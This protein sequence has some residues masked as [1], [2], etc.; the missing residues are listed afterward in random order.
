MAVTIKDL[1]REAGVSV[2]TVS[3]AL[4]GL[5]GVSIQT[6]SRILELAKT[7]GYTRNS[8]A[9][10]LKTGRKNR[11]GLVVSG[12]GE[13]LPSELELIAEFLENCFRRNCESRVE[14]FNFFHDGV[15][16]ALFQD[17]QMGGIVLCGYFGPQ[18]MKRITETRV[19]FVQ[20]NE[21]N[22]SA[23]LFPDHADCVVKL[24]NHLIRTGR[25]RIAYLDGE[26]NRFIT[27]TEGR[28]GFFDAMKANGIP[29]DPSRIYVNSF[30]RSFQEDLVLATEKFFLNRP[31]PADAVIC[32]TPGY[33]T[34]LILHLLKQGIQVPE[35]V[36]VTCRFC[37]LHYATSHYP[38]MTVCTLDY[39][40]LVRETFDLLSSLIKGKRPDNP[41]RKM[42][43]SL[44][45]RE[46]GSCHF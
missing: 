3:C 13:G 1:A 27:T 17:A 40:R 10:A 16:P 42:E 46:N 31:D 33:A 30:G 21:P 35:Q 26:E 41:V 39:E 34:A 11:I 28:R 23:A 6:R 15:L 36:I 32:Q 44:L 14:R 38:Q 43:C 29:A 37:S 25:K 18:T 12:Y 22:E 5:Q 24:V 8:A 2:F 45:V 4:N 7:R 9:A 19:P 20:V